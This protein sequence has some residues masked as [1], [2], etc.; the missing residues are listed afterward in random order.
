MK[1]DVLV[2]P[3][4]AI[5]SM[6]TNSKAGQAGRNY[7]ESFDIP[8]LPPTDRLIGS[9]STIAPKKIPVEVRKIKIYDEIFRL[10]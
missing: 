10:H 4:S 2:V 8:L 1:Q 7:V 3:N 9:I 5:K 6:P